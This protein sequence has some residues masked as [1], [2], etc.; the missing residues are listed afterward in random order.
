[1]KILVTLFM[2]Y[3]TPFS[4]VYTHLIPLRESLRMS[5]RPRPS[6]GSST[7]I[8]SNDSFFAE[9]FSCAEVRRVS[10]IFDRE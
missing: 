1:M 4:V 7:T 6:G 2:K 3:G 5:S 9:R 10:M 8:S